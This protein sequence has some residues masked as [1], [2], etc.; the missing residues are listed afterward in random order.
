M[1]DRGQV[2]EYLPPTPLVVVAVVAVPDP[3][4]RAVA[5]DLPLLH[6]VVNPVSGFTTFFSPF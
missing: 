6:Q 2:L 1:L 3:A 4:G 5:A